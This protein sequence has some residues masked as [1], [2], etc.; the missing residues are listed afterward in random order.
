LLTA[1]RVITAAQDATRTVTAVVQFMVDY[2]RMI[3]RHITGQ[4]NEAPVDTPAVLINGARQTGKSSGRL[5]GI[6][7]KAAATLSG[8]DVRGLQALESAAGKKWVR[9][10]I[11]YTGAEVIPFA[12]NRHGVPITHLWAR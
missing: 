11:L 4:V 12:N 5:V 6:E 7:V 3:S 9:G 2:R 10:V 8:G 1:C